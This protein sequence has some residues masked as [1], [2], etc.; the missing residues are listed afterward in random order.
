MERYQFQVDGMRC[1]GCERIIEN[2]LT[3]NHDVSEADA[4]HES[5]A[6]VVTASEPSDELADAIRTLG[7]DVEL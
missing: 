3:A 2:E 5:D 6:V 4:D 7:Y 1:D